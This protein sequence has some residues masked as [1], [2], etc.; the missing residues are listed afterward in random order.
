MHRPIEARAV[1]A[2]VVLGWRQAREQR[3]ALIGQAALYVIVLVIFWQLWRATPLGEL[4]AAAPSPQALLWYLVITEWIVFT[5]AARYREIEAEVLGGTLESELLRPLP[6]AIATLAR[7]AGSSA[8]QLAVLGVVGGLAGWGLTGSLPPHAELLPW[9]VLSAVLALAL[10]L[11]CHL[12]LGYAA[13]W[14][15]TAAPAFWIWQKLLF[16]FGGLLFPLSLYPPV[17]RD[18]AENSPFAAMLF[19]PASLVFGASAA[20]LAALLANQLVWLG[21]LAA[22]AV[23]VSRRATARVVH[24]AS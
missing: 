7:W 18:A 20:R 8:Y 5:A 24:G 2:F 17:L 6:H 9:V 3:L 11:L 21:V 22:L 1:W 4:G 13:L 15:G 12:Q 14:T 16:V 23:L 19:A 10:A